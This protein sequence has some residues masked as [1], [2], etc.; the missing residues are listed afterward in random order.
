MA[1]IKNFTEG[2]IFGPLIKFALPVMLALLLQTMYGAVDLW[3]VGKFG[4]VADISGV[5]TGSQLMSTLTNLISGLSMGLTVL[6]GQKIGQRK[7][8]E[9][10]D[11]VGSG[12]CLFAVIALVFTAVM[13]VFS[14]QIVTLMNAPEES[15]EQ[16][17]SYFFIC[18]CGMLLIVAYN[19]IGS[20][21]R[22]IGDSNTPLIA[23]AIACVFN[24]AGD[25]ILVKGF[26]MGATG[27]AIATV[28]AQGLSVLISLMILKHRKLPFEFSKKSLRFSKNY[29]VGTLGMGFPIALQSALVGISFLFVTAIV[30]KMG[31]VASAAIGVSEK[32]SGFIMLVPISMMQSLSAFV[33]QNYGARR[34]GR[35]RK[36]TYYGMAISFVYGVLAFYFTFFHGDLL[37]GLFNKDA[38][39]VTSTFEY[40][41]AMS[42][43]TLMVP[44]LFCFIG[45]FNGCGRTAFSLV[46]SAIGAFGIR[47]PLAYI[48]SRSSA[49]TL[50][51]VGLA[52]PTSTVVQIILCAIFFIVLNKKFKAEALAAQI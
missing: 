35:A 52:T 3:V 30:N 20:V 2:N 14:R 40:L 42:I 22:G 37:A 1:K 10:G 27:A 24:V 16:T 12:I 33:A 48:I 11:V 51:N 50:F 8:E 9:A 19:L 46:Q 38:N 25:L 31:V 6:L 43:D 28:I 17:L 5:T 44:F 4:T 45:Y 36:A 23:V 15:F 13:V 7:E 32:L 39:V 34:M 41:K 47:I 26:G 18:T 21:F 29:V 49:A